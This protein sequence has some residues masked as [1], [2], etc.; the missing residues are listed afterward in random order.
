MKKGRKGIKKSWKKATNKS[1][2]MAKIKEK[3][4]QRRMK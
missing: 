3:K 4:K 2:Y 1:S